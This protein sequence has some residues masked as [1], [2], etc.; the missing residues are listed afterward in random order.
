MTNT[1]GLTTSAVSTGG[2]PSHP[3]E[4]QVS[5]IAAATIVVE[6]TSSYIDDMIKKLSQVRGSEIPIIKAK[7]ASTR[8]G[9]VT[10]GRGVVSA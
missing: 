10:E 6:E 7:R 1:E 8:A 2:M 4:L 5:G 3:G 9:D